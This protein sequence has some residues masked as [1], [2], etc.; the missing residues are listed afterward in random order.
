M[1]GIVKCLFGKEDISKGSNNKLR[2]EKDGLWWRIYI[3]NVNDKRSEICLISEEI[4]MLF[5][6]KDN[7]FELIYSIWL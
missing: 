7:M 2:R 3:L 5:K 1:R 6:F 4:N